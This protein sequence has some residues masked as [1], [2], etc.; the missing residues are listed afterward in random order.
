MASSHNNTRTPAAFP[1]AKAVVA[2][3]FGGLCVHLLVMLIDYFL[4]VTPM[5]LDLRVDFAGVVFSTAM[6]PMIVAYGLLSVSIYFLWEKHKRS[7]LLAREATIEREKADALLKS[8][9]HV[10]SLL[11]EHIA[12][13][14]SEVLSWIGQ[15]KLKGQT[16]SE[17]IERPSKKIAEALHAL[18]ETSFVV[19]FAGES[20]ADIGALVDILQGKLDRSGADPVDW[21]P[22]EPRRAQ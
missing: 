20:P 22:A 4:M 3:I 19:P 15:K 8:M 10:T 9:Q 18:T 16:V 2:F 6:I 17:K 13:H 11:A 7:V 1:V 21:Q 5:F 12:H 14:N